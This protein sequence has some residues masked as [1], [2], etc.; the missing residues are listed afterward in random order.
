M[1]LHAG[2]DGDEYDEEEEAYLA[3]TPYHKSSVPGGLWHYF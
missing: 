1:N 3:V 2:E